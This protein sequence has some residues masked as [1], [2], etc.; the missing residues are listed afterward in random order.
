MLALNHK[1]ANS[2]IF[3]S[4]FKQNAVDQTAI[5]QLVERNWLEAK[6]AVVQVQ[7]SGADSWINA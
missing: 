7:C 1:P 2:T 6:L 4:H 5:S 3:I